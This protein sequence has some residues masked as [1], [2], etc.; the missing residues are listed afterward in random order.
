MLALPP[1][2]G[3]VDVDDEASSVPVEYEVTELT[4]MDEH[5]DHDA[6]RAQ[7]VYGGVKPNKPAFP[8]GNRPP[9]PQV[10]LL[11]RSQNVEFPDRPLMK[12]TLPRVASR[13][14]PANNRIPP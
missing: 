8:R 2:A 7:S 1:I 9:S 6:H 13:H 10:D 4:D 11:D 3:K 14:S 5:P 12:S